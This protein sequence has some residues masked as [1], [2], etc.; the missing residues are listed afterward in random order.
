MST[1]EEQLAE[2]RGQFVRN[3]MERLDKIERSIDVLEHSPADKETLK[4]LFTHF[5][6]L[7]GMGGTY[8][9]DRV[10][11]VSLRAEAACDEIQS[12]GQPVRPEELRALRSLTGEIRQA[13]Q[14]GQPQPADEP[15]QPFEVLLVDD[16]H[17]TQVRFTQIM[18]QEGIIVRAAGTR[19]EAEQM[20]GERPPQA[21]VVNSV[22]PDG[23][24]YAVVEKLRAQPNGDQV[25]VIVIGGQSGFMDKVE[26][27]RCGADSF[28]EK[29]VDWQAL[30]RRFQQL[31]VRVTQEPSRILLVEDEQDQ[32][33]MVTSILG[34]GGYTV[35]H[36]ADPVHFEADLRSFRP[37]LLLL[38]V[39]LPGMSGFELARYVR[40]REEYA[41]VPILFLTTAGQADR[42]LESIK[43]GADDY[44]LKPIRPGVLLSTVAGRLERSRV[45]R[46]LVE[47]DGLTGL[48][49]HSAFLERAKLMIKEVQTSARNGAPVMVMLDVDHF[50]NVNDT[51]GHPTGDRVLASLSAFLRRR[52]RQTDS[53]G[54]YGGEEFAILLQ[55]LTAQQAV[56]LIEKLL[57]EFRAVEHLSPEGRSFNVTFSAGIA[58][59]NKDMDLNLWNA[60]AD[61]A[62]LTAKAEGRDR[63][64]M[65]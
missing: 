29:P 63:V 22:L 52:L 34:S 33:N 11:E 36:C 51:F 31:R 19:M 6:G 53:I 23:S 62:L 26:A 2:F 32:A 44:L 54:R 50:K 35:R 28:F 5:H 9:F 59:L 45:L 21:A 46:S 39:H 60:A 65:G 49:T 1:P 27:I 12:S 56:T 47:H 64:R 24:G 20:I 18:V 30:L 55:D 4:T 42:R 57:S 40:Q 25:I 58:L 41:T 14:S 7:A 3:S 43:A 38:D 16:D 15:E 37:D 8:G 61:N 48:L 17:E 10:S 13:F